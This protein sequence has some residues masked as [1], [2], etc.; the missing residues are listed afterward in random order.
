VILVWG[1]EGDAPTDAV[2]DALVRS[3]APHVMVDQ[4]LP[5]P[6]PVRFDF[7]GRFGGNLGVVDLDEV[8]AV[9]MRPQGADAPGDSCTAPAERA[10]FDRWLLAWTELTPALV[11][12]RLSAQASNTSKL[13]QAS[14]I[15]SSGFAVPDSLATTDPVAARMFVDRHPAVIYKSLSGVRSIVRR[16]RPDERDRLDDVSGCP[17]LFQE[18]VA[19]TDYRVH[20]V[21]EELFATMVASESDD[22]RYDRSTERVAVTLP[23]PLAGRCVALARALAL[24]VAGI[25]LRATPTGDWVCFEVNPAP[26]FPYFEEGTEVAD[27]IARLL[28]AG[29]L[30]G[31]RGT[32]PVP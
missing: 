20:V 17:T 22:Y 10:R 4:R 18:Y 12:T 14:V 28:A 5:L 3:G 21:G 29:P 11:V 8:T 24:P 16:L 23:G 9:F 26:A 30:N 25:D 27:A 13:F 7:G 2:V 6:A 1:A 32:A 15:A 31:R 19:G